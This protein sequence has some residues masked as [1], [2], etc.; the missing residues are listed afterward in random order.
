MSDRAVSSPV[1]IVLILGITVA[2]VTALFAVGGAVVSD[3]R[4]DAERSQMENA[5]SGF[6]SKAS[7][8]GLGESGDQRFSLGRA[9]EGDVTVY[10]DAGRVTLYINRTGEPDREELNSTSLG[11]VVYESGDVEVAYQGGGVWQ[12][13]GESSWMISPPEYRYR[14]ETLTFP[15]MT[16]S[17][18][19]RSSGNVAGTVRTAS[20]SDVWF[21][22]GSDEARSNPLDNGTVLVEVESRY[23]DGWERFFNERSQGKID[24]ECGDD[25]TVV[26]DLTV[27]FD[28]EPD[29]PVEAKSIEKNGNV[30]VPDSWAEDVTAPSVSPEVESQLEACQETGC[31]SLPQSGTITNGTYWS[32]G[33][34]EFD[35][36]ATF[37]TSGGDITAVIDGELELNDDIDITGSGRA[38]VYVHGSVDKSG[39]P[40]V[41]TGGGADQLA[42][43]VH[44]DADSVDL[45]GNVQFTGVMYAPGSEVD[46]NGNTDVRGAVIGDEVELNGEPTDVTGADELE[47]YQLLSGD[48]PL[49]YLHVSENA[50]EVEFE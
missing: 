26:V 25:D 21:P 46:I 7:L 15:I 23:C 2:S 13:R 43:L 40:N 9:S 49:T 41:N 19:G 45:S 50:V 8:V 29:V 14:L 36:P 16:V 44:S 20:T 24:Q 12:R 32:D 22:I 33:E 18:D 34:H 10:P 4:A 6:S 42:V 27:P 38:T 37:D 30:G 17:G 35:G 48:R 11:A 5:M 28:I 3:T 31:E 1:G 39:N 47:G